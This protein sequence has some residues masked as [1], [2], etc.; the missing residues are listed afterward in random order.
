MTTF[1][2]GQPVACPDIADAPA[3]W[4]AFSAGALALGVRSAHA[5]PLRLRATVIGTLNLFG[6]GVGALTESDLRVARA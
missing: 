1:T 4:A 3:E 6:A 2:T 5:V